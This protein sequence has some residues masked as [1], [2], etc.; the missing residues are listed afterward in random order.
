MGFPSLVRFVSRISVLHLISKHGSM[1]L[2]RECKFDA[3]KK[4]MCSNVVVAVV[5]VCMYVCMYYNVMV[6][7]SQNIGN[8]I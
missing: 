3:S 8:S 2:D 6:A 1:E 7:T 4:Q 5:V